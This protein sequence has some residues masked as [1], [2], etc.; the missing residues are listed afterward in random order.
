M[1]SQRSAGGE[2]KRSEGRPGAA[3][4]RQAT[5]EELLAEFQRVLESA[6]YPPS[7]PPSSA[8]VASVS[9]PTAEPRKST[10]VGAAR[11]SADDLRVGEW[12]NR[13]PTGSGDRRGGRQDSI[14]VTTRVRPSRWQIAASAL[15]LGLA[16]VAGAGLGLV[17]TAPAPKPPVSHVSAERQSNVQPPV[18]ESAAP[19]SV[20]VKDGPRADHAEVGDSIVPVDASESAVKAPAQAPLDAQRPAD[21]SNAAAVGTP[22]DTPIPATAAASAPT[23]SQPPVPSG[24]VGLDRTPIATTSSNSAVSTSPSETPKPQGKAAAV[25]KVDL[26]RPQAA[27]IDTATTPT[28]G[29]PSAQKIVEKSAKAKMG[30]TAEI[31]HP[32]LRPAPPAR[33]VVSPAVPTAVEPVPVAPAPPTPPSSFAAQSVSQLT[34]AFGYL[35]HLP[36]ALI[37][38]VI[39]PSPEAQ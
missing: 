36:G 3:T 29:K 33:A 26:A 24:S 14:G 10:D 37:G 9:A 30:A 20:S 21:A 6:G 13:G 27:K 2:P 12:P 1:S 32:P 5:A 23:A 19:S 25:A 34:N 17:L 39:G 8:S 16:A 38:R 35:T 4:T 31:P 18:E 11:D 22:A 15:A 28:A 7:A